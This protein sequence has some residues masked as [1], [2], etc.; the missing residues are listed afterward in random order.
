MLRT[1]IIWR[2]L[3][4]QNVV[5]KTKALYL[6]PDIGLLNSRGFYPTQTYATTAADPK[7]P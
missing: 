7:L 4:T 1:G 2:K 3:G 6:W 5:A